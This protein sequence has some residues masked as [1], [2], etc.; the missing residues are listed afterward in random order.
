M[1]HNKTRWLLGLVVVVMFAISPSAQ[2]IAECSCDSSFTV[3]VGDNG[4]C[5][6]GHWLS[7]EVVVCLDECRVFIDGFAEYPKATP[8]GVPVAEC[9]ENRRRIAESRYNSL[10]TILTSGRL[11]LVTTYKTMHYP[12]D[13]RQSD[14]VQQAIA[15]MRSAPNK[16][17]KEDW[18]S[19]LVTYGFAEALRVPMDIG[20]CGRDADD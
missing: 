4:V 16:I 6:Y 2:A 11:Y 10:I 15:A 5:M 1:H 18:V 7:G 17:N 20:L 12:L 14:D 13:I 9:S 19:T 8:G 3:D